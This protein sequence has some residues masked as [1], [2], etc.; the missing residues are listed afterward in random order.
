MNWVKRLK[1]KWSIRSTWQFVIVMVVFALTGTTVLIIKRPV[2]A[3]FSPDGE[4]NVW[5]SVA[6][7]IL[8][9]PMYNVI[10]LFYGFVLG[11]FNFFWKYEKKIF[12]R[13]RRKHNDVS[14]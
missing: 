6:Y 4:Q 14:T 10:L 3:Y 12:K 9:L 7:Y 2:V 13:F 1:E 11:Q 8:I 5:F